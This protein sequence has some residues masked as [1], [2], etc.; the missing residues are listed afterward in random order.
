MSRPPRPPEQPILTASDWRR[1]VGYGLLL[2]VAVTGALVLAL[3]WL[4]LGEAEAVTVSFATLALAQLWHVFNVRDPGSRF[5]DNDV[6]RNPWVWAALAF[7]TG[8]LVAAVY[9][10]VLSAALGTRSP[11]AAGWALAVGASLVPWAVGQALL[12]WLG[13]RR[14]TR[15][16]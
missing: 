12:A 2:T 6:V 3:D 5:A 13:R 14:A 16:A 1:I 10:P 7:C 8:L 11:G 15:P 9:A 4:E